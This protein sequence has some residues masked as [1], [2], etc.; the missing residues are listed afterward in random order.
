MP[1]LSTPV[2]T[3]TAYDK[4]TGAPV[5]VDARTFN[6]DTMSRAPIDLETKDD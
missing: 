3:F 5:V 1:D 6:A 2:T 4:A